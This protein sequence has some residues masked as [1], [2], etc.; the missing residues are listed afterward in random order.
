M[1]NELKEVIKNVRQN[2]AII[3]YMELHGLVPKP[4]RSIGEVTHA[5][6]EEMKLAGGHHAYLPE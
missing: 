1:R 6:I 3:E 5:L 4:F 2:E